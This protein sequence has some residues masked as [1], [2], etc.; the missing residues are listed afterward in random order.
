M[1]ATDDLEQAKKSL[2]SAENTITALNPDKVIRDML[3]ALTHL[4]TSVEKILSSM[5]K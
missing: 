5:A 1:D 3:T 2:K 4:T